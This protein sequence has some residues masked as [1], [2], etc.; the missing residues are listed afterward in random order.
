LITVDRTAREFEYV[1]YDESDDE[2]QK[3]YTNQVGNTVTWAS[4][5]SEVVLD[6]AT[7]GVSSFESLLGNELFGADT[8]YEATQFN[9]HAQSE[10]TINGDRH[11]LEL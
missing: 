9:F 5:T 8:Q 11:D 3:V 2:F 1:V 7:N 4:Q 10:H 6:G